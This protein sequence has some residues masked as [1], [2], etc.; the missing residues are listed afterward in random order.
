M[1]T[2]LYSRAAILTAKVESTEGTDSVP[3]AGTDDVL[4]SDLSIEPLA[5]SE[6]D[7]SYIR[8]Y[9]GASPSL[10]VEDYVTISCTVD[11][12]GTATP[13]TAP[14]WAVLLKGCGFAQ[15]LLASAVTGAAQAGTTNTITLAAGA[16]STTNL[17]VG[18]TISY[19]TGGTDFGAPRTIIAYD[20]TSKI[21]TVNKNFAVT[22]GASSGYSIGTN[23]TYLPVSTGFTSLSIYYNISGVL[24]KMTG[25]KGSFSIDLSASARPALKFTF[26]GV[27]NP[28]VDAAAG[29]PVFTAFQTPQTVNSSNTSALIAGKQADGSATGVQLMKFDLDLANAVKH[30]QLIGAAGVILTDRAPKGNVSIEATTVTFS[31]WFANIR[32]STKS[33][34]LIENGLVAGNVVSL[35]L[36]SAQL[37][38]P[39][40][41]DSDGIVMLDASVRALPLNGNDEVRIVVK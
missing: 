34:L 19:T 25:C 14:P 29:T 5:G 33:P 12:A 21:A 35:F 2:R 38:E 31:D 18:A 15:T 10:R 36:P 24:H 40:Y 30:R 22:P 27:Y 8:P 20:G 17:Y 7:L 28:P 39:K 32:S 1:S 41:S 26:T 16:S 13:G 9:Y 3:A 37:A 11:W 4:V 6:I 23:A